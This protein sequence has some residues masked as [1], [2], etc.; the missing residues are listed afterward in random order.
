MGKF[1]E[2]FKYARN[3]DIKAINKS[4]RD[5]G[6]K[7]HAVYM[8]N[9]MFT[10][11][12]NANYQLL[13]EIQDAVN[14]F[15]R[16]VSDNYSIKRDAQIALQTQYKSDI[17]LKQNFKILNNEQL[18]A[19]VYQQAM[20]YYFKIDTKNE[21]GFSPYFDEAVKYRIASS[22]LQS[23]MR[24]ILT[25]M[26]EDIEIVIEDTKNVDFLMRNFTKIERSNSLFQYILEQLADSIRNVVLQ[27]SK[28]DEEY[29]ATVR[30]ISSVLQQNFY[31]G[32]IYY[33]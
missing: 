31:G 16:A 21:F 22:F 23:D 14:S 24:S 25:K 29:F 19:L 20:E 12:I 18:L 11:D 2:V 8:T 17:I 10:N 28:F 4:I 7:H 9:M 30:R 32:Q 3:N 13:S 1:S 15:Y 6:R 5:V 27:D 26:Y 33:G